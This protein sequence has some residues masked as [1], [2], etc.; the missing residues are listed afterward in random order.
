VKNQSI[1]L[2][3]NL[4]LLLVIGTMDRTLIKQFKRTHQ[5]SLP[6]FD[7]LREIVSRAKVVITTP[8]ILTEVS[9]LAN[10]L[11]EDQKGFFAEIFQAFIKEL[12]ERFTAATV[13]SSDALFRFGIAD[14][15]AL[16][17]AS[18]TLVLTQDGRFAAQIFAA[19]GLALDLRSAVML[20]REML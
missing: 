17:E 11:R 5:F 18:S 6:D 20:G 10:S 2:D 9:N 14:V 8:H 4:L 7:A 15:S 3:S 19:G 12:E 13:L 1:F 16:R